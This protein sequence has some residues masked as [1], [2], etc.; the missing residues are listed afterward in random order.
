MCGDSPRCSTGIV[1]VPADGLN[2]RVVPNGPP[3]MSLVNGT[4]LILCRNKVIGCL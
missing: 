3:V 1:N 4:P 2:I